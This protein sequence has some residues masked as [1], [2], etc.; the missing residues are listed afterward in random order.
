MTGKITLA[1]TVALLTLVAGAVQVASA[2]TAPSPTVAHEQVFA[3]ERAF[4][5]AMQDRDLAAFTTLLSKDAVFYG[6]SVTRGPAAVAAAWKPLFAGPTAP[7]SWEP[8]SVEVI[9]AGTLA[10]SSGPVRGP[11]GRQTSTYNSIWRL[12]DG[13]WRVVF[14]KG[15]QCP[16]PPKPGA[17]AASCAA[18]N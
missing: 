18:Q 16:P 8:T 5:K 6:E 9:D 10:L 17:D 4:A 12:E 2:Q 15:C 3:A 13:A 11:D 1:A 7:F 14:D